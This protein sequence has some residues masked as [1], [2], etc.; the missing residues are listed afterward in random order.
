M[1]KVQKSKKEGRF[2]QGTT[3]SFMHS[4]SAKAYVQS[5]HPS[6]GQLTTRARL[7]GSPEKSCLT[8]FAWK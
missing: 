7:T 3:T 1:R 8:L 6:I 4:R 2:D 5:R